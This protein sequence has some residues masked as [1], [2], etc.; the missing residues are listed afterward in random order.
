MTK[1]RIVHVKI[2][3]LTLSNG[4]WDFIP[5]IEYRN[6]YHIEMQFSYLFFLKRWK[7][8]GRVTNYKRAEIQIKFLKQKE[9]RTIL[10]EFK[11]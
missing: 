10:K 5:E 1:Y 7:N 4:T 3:E 2:P 8:I 11:F 6:E 9:I